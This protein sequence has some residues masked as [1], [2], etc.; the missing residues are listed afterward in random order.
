ETGADINVDDDG[1]IGTVTIGAKEGTAVADAEKRIQLILN[2]P[3]ASVGEIYTGKVVNI[4]KF[5]AFVNILPG[6]DGL[7]HISKLGKGKRVERVEDV[8]TL[9]V[10][11]EV[12][13]DDVDP[14]GKVALSP[15]TDLVGG[16]EGD[17]GSRPERGGDRGSRG[18][19][20]G[21]APATDAPAAG[22]DREFVSFED[23][24]QG[25]ARQAF[26]DLGPE[27][28]ASPARGGDES[29]GPRRNSGPR[30]SNRR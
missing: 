16:G 8:L 25:E 10:D 26:G 19:S 13:V 24:F 4:T 18:S 21:A 6:R 28:A 12:M 23:S 22:G 3:T 1:T 11:I 27:A 9:G 5:G 7:L 17:G 15:V 30:R 14:Q 2:P 20:R 29:R